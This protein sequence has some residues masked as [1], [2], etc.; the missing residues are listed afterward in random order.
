LYFY[1]PAPTLGRLQVPVL[2]LFGELDNNILAAKN[3]AAWEAALKAAGNRDY[4]LLILPKAN[5]GMFEAQI[6]SNA[7]MRTLQRLVPAYF[8]TVHDWL[9]KRVRALDPPAPV[10]TQPGG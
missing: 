7:E 4:T 9:T 8:A 6:G 2:A 1:D 10:R 3:K 5:H